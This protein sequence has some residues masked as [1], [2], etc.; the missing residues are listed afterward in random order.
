ME[1][2][3]ALRTAMESGG[4]TLFIGAGVCHNYITSDGRAAPDGR[5]LARRL[6][7]NLDLDPGAD[8]D[9]AKIAQ[10]VELRRDRSTLERLIINEL[11]GIEPDEHLLWLFSKTWRAIFTT[12]YDRVI[13]RSYELISDPTQEPVTFTAS[14]DTVWVDPRLQVGIFHLHGS[15]FEGE[16]RSALIT[17]NDYATF[18]EQRSM[19]F[20][21]LKQSFATSPILYIGYSN[22]DP[23]WEVVRAELRSEFAPSTPPEAYRVA[24]STDPIDEEILAAQGVF[25]LAGTLEDFR[26]ACERDLPGL[27]VEPSKLDD[28]KTTIPP[29]L[30]GAFEESP[31][32]VMRLLKAW[33]YV[34]Q[35]DFSAP[36]NTHAFLRGD[37]PTWST[38]AHGVAFERDVEEPLYEMLLDGATDPTQR[39]RSQILLGPAGYGVST[40]LRRLA[41]R[42]AQDQVGT[43]LWHRP[44]TPF[45]VADV[46]FAATSLP[47]PVFFIVDNASDADE[48][49]PG[50]VT[51]LRERGRDANFVFGD[52]LNE[53]RQRR[54]RMSPR[55]WALESLSEAEIDGL[56]DCLSAN[57]ELG[58]LEELPRNL[59]RAAVREKHGKE[60]LV[61][62]REAT[63]GEGFD[64]I[65]ADEFWSL[66]SEAAQSIYRLVAALYRTRA[67]A[68]VGL[69]ASILRLNPVQIYQVANQELEGVVIF[70]TIDEELDITVAR[71]RH[72]V[73][74]DMIWSRCM[75]RSQR[76]DLL[77][78]VVREV[79]L[80]F[81]ADAL[82]FDRLVRSDDV[83]DDIADI[84]GRVEFFERACRKDPSSPYVRQHYAR[85]LRRAGLYEEALAQ[86]DAGLRLGARRALHHT[87]G[88]ILSDMAVKATSPELGRRRL[89]QAEQA[90]QQVL[91]LNPRDEYAFQ[92]LADLYLQWAMRAPT[93]VEKAEYLKQCERT[94]SDGLT[95]VRDKEGLWIISASVANFLDDAPGVLEALSRAV[96]GSPEAL[97]AR[98]LL[99]R[100]YE[101]R[102]ELEAAVDTLMPILEVQPD[103]Y[104]AAIVAAR[105]MYKLGR[106]PSEAAAILNLASLTGERDARFVALLSGL[107][108]LAGN[109]DEA[110][111]LVRH[112]EG[113]G[114]RVHEQNRV[115]FVAEAGGTVTRYDGAIL[116]LRGG[117]AFLRTSAFPQDIFSPGSELSSHGLKE[118]SRVRF[119]LGFTAR[120]PKAFDLESIVD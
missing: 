117:Y 78:Q 9:L 56:L 118:G 46:E 22:S 47:G 100:E 27:R 120:G 67:S 92:G 12:N 82:A 112:A 39:V 55:E 116:R 119:S 49:L 45:L 69:M 114:F 50:A 26:A 20:D 73:I 38:I 71:P 31:P 6:A 21:F 19:L 65:V 115:E 8:P 15:L 74:A 42:L 105:S 17:A 1:L 41:V 72:H 34:N 54:L 89:I 23:N 102:G 70:E 80:N 103:Q 18:R 64:A 37:A 79:N 40:L 35:E 77:L 51:Q 98:Y 58:V 111:R 60:L 43:V 95:K 97:V 10:L 13:Q 4:V 24:P 63:S 11:D 106:P 29:G 99:G 62:M 7:R 25:T 86:V 81:P 76:E 104:R 57:R 33:S 28:I 91:S 68:R 5:E 93:A 36:L 113:A 66:P 83:V 96:D 52:R 110:T 88:V 30:I 3:L 61:A 84:E 14:R 109:F 90:F 107:Q 48:A 16:H 87:R 75:D 2:P 59:Q 94:V 101:E 32:A 108:F 53:W 44:G 85:M